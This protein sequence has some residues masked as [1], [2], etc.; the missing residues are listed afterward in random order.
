MNQRGHIVDHIGAL[1]RTFK[2][3]C[4]DAS[5][6]QNLEEYCGNRA[7]WKDCHQLFQTIRAKTL[8]AE[9]SRNKKEIAQY[10][11]EE[12]C[13]KTLHNLSHSPAPFDA[14]SPY[15]IVPNAIVFAREMGLSEEVIL[16]IVAKDNTVGEV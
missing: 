8:R 16:G 14:D 15:W 6:L 2:L 9:K 7:R 12:V 1:A 11:F 3:V 10:C 13:A 4:A 5:T